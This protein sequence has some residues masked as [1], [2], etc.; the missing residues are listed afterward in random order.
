MHNI[1]MKIN[2]ICIFPIKELIYEEYAASKFS[3]S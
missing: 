3:E 2:G 1:R